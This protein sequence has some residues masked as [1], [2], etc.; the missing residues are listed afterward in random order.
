MKDWLWLIKFYHKFLFS[1]FIEM[2][3]LLDSEIKYLLT[4]PLF[5]HTKLSN[6]LHKIKQW[7]ILSEMQV[8]IK[9]K[10]NQCIHLDTNKLISFLLSKNI[11]STILHIFYN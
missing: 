2:L 4:F 1:Y 7:C 5:L 9:K 10:T 3:S 11:K 6:Y 8:N